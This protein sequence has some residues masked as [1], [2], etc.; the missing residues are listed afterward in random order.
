MSLFVCDKCNPASVCVESSLVSSIKMKIQRHE[1]TRGTAHSSGLESTY[2]AQ[3]TAM[4]RVMSSVG[5]PTEVSTM[6]MVT[7]PDCGIPAAPM[8]AAEAV[9]LQREGGCATQTVVFAWQSKFLL[10]GRTGLDLTSSTFLLP[11]AITNFPV[12]SRGW[13][14]VPWLCAPPCLQGR[15]FLI[16]I[17]KYLQ[18]Y[19]III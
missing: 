12:H 16:K 7:S 1:L 17:T 2:R 10:W 15:D 3:S 19:L 8:L 9:M 18:M 11:G 6:T 4:M 14:P 5:S 13:Q